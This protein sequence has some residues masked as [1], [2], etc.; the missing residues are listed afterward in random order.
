MSAVVEKLLQNAFFYFEQVLEGY[1]FILVSKQVSEKACY[2]VN[3]YFF[4]IVQ[5]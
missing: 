3:L 5:K 1:N 2:L 4:I